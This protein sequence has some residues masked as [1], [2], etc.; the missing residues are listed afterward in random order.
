M[1]RRQLDILGSNLLE[2]IYHML[3][4]GEARSIHYLI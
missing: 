3:V 4:I 1:E 2:S